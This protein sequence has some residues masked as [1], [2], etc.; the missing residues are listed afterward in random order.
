VL[1][2]LDLGDERLYVSEEVAELRAGPEVLQVIVDGGPADP[3]NEQL[4]IFGAL[5]EVIAQQY[6][7]AFSGTIAA[8]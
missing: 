1:H 8:R 2:L 5:A 6:W 7:L 3:Q 4:R